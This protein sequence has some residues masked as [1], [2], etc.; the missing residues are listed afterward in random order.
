MFDQR[1]KNYY[2][3]GDCISLKSSIYLFLWFYIYMGGK[4]GED[5]N[6]IKN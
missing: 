4:V 5:V 6:M 3:K 2:S 1:R